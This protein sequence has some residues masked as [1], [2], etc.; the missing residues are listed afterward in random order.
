M[1]N[2]PEQE[3]DLCPT[4]PTHSDRA[5]TQHAHFTL[6]GRTIVDSDRTHTTNNDDDWQS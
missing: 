5:G 2:Q 3:P 1:V 4:L 6:A